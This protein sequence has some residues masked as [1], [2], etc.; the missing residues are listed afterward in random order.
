MNQTSLNHASST[1]PQEERR[2]HERKA[3]ADGFA[4]DILPREGA[5]E[6]AAKIINDS[7]DGM[8][9]L[10][11]EGEAWSIKIGDM[12]ALRIHSPDRTF[13]RQAS[14]SWVKNQGGGRY[15]GFSFVDVARFEPNS[16][17]LKITEIRV[18]PV[19]ALKIPAS[20]ALRRRV[21]PFVQLDGVTHVACEDKENSATVDI[22]ERLLKSEVQFWEVDADELKP[23]LRRVY[24]DGRATAVAVAGQDVAA[25]GDELLYAAYLRQASDIHIDP[26]PKGMAVR[27]RVDGKLEFHSELPPGMQLELVSRFK[28]LSGMDISE[29]RA[30]QDGRFSF[31]PPG[32]SVQVDVRAATLPTKYGERLTLR[33]LALQTETLTL[34]R[35]G[36]EPAYKQSIE[37]FLRRSQG[38]MILTGPTGSGKTTTLY[39]SIRMLLAERNLNVMTIEDPI[40]YAIEGVA[41]CEVDSADKVSFAKALRS[42][43]RHDPDVV[44]IGEI[45]DQETAEIAMKA[46]LTGHLVLSTLHT[47]SSAATV[48]RLLDIGLEP[49]LVAGTLRLAISQRL[50]RKLCSHCRIPRALTQGEAITLNRPH[51]AGTTVFEPGGCIYCA[52][53]GF[54]G[55]VGLYELLEMNAAWSREIAEGAG[56]SRLQENMREA[57]VSFLED[58]AIA[59][60]FKGVISF[61]DTLQIV[62]S[63]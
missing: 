21:L 48:S 34:D 16:H 27:F 23:V 44:M 32:H 15:C 31:T 17:L 18:D 3:V 6:I 35:L 24:G 58:D 46:A 43:L 56:E 12:V 57:G 13:S 62:N 53:R 30:P 5:M 61:A 11:N 2:L 50:S 54:S 39:A 1:E 42:I 25:V 60:L 51:L 9:L 38:M 19:C 49:Y 14:T 45:R 41:Q 37:N 55:R 26:W 63:W 36:L 7:T 8:G 29:R 28:V 20:V 22:V 4:V 40:E 10:I 59:K 52:G 33:L 47:N